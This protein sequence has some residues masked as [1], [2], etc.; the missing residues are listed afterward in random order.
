LT[1]GA[2]EHVM[3]VG[4]LPSGG[5]RPLSERIGEAIRNHRKAKQFTQLGFADH[6]EMH[7]AYYG[8]KLNVVRKISR[9]Q[10]SSESASD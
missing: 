7:R 10:H 6:I 5:Y 4:E 8:G 9:Y 2:G 1:A 3:L